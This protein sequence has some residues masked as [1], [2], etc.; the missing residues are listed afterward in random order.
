MKAPY[1]KIHSVDEYGYDQALRGLALSWHGNPLKMPRVSEKLA[2]KLY[3]GEA[4][5]LE[6]IKLW[7]TLTAPRYWWQEAD[8]YRLTSK[9]SE[10][11][12]HTLKRIIGQ[13][14]GFDDDK[15]ETKDHIIQQNFEDFRGL[16]WCMINLLSLYKEK[17]PLYELKAALPEA[18]LQMRLWCMSYKD[19]AHIITQRRGHKL[20]HWVMF[21]DEM[22][23]RVVHPELLP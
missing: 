3:T 7:I 23:G 2:P 20:P 14:A 21:I 15:H 22:K 9:Q 13:I 4:K 6:H 1:I 5:F 18:F 12:M 19:L 17:P 10:S 8:T 11:T 16:N